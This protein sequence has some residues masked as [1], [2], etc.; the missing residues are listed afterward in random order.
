MANVV[1]FDVI[2]TLLDLRALDSDFAQLFGDAGAREQWFQRVLKTA[3]TTTVT[4]AYQDFGAIGGA[5]L[6]MTATLRGMRVSADDKRHLRA[7]LTTLPAHPDVMGGLERLK[8]AG[9]RLATLSNN[10][11]ESSE[12]QLRNANLSA[13]F[14]QM[15]S[16]HD[17][18]RLKPAPEPYRYAAEQLGVHVSGMWMV[19]AHGWDIQGAAR[20]GCRTAFVDR[21]GHVLSPLADLPT[22]T[23]PDIEAVAVRLLEQPSE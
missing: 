18:R 6:D 20:A 4:G 13:F 23:G 7:A 21:P 8:D 15:L 14:D 3:L 5:A 16:A 10:P 17:V 9:F 22:V 12:A 19:A 11:R 1:V 2:E